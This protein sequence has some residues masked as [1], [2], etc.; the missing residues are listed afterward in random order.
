M[1]SSPA[2]TWLTPRG[3]HSWVSLQRGVGM[4]L[5]TPEGLGRVLGHPD[6]AQSLS[7][8]LLFELMFPHSQRCRCAGEASPDT[9][10]RD[11]SRSTCRSPTRL[12]VRSGWILSNHPAEGSKGTWLPAPGLQPPE[13]LSAAFPL[14]TPA[15]FSLPPSPS[16]RSR[17]IG[18]TCCSCVS[19]VMTLTICHRQVSS[20]RRAAAA[21]SAQ[22][23][24]ADTFPCLLPSVSGEVGHSQPDSSDRIPS[25]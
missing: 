7:L 23:W 25:Q 5:P 16:A 9:P 19:V 12:H 22:S 24:Q 4:D 3:E 17:L 18:E 10:V 8:S 1:C 6:E 13:R 21:P 2:R 14:W 11:P 15:P 20:A